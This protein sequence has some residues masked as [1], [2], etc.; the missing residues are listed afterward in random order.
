MADLD[1]STKYISTEL[2][3][4][5]IIARGPPQP[6]KDETVK[7]F[8]TFKFPA[9]HEPEERWPFLSDPILEKIRKHGMYIYFWKIK[10]HLL[11]NTTLRMF[12]KGF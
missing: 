10:Y 5:E 1:L 4:A 9:Y 8:D 3:R 7:T 2:R 6:G 12:F 11:F